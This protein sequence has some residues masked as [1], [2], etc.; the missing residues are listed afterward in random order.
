L[1]TEVNSLQED[2]NHRQLLSSTATQKERKAKS[3]AGVTIEH[4]D[5]IKDDF[6]NSRPW[7]LTGGVGVLRQVQPTN[8]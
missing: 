3:K 8:S 4:L 1:D 7:I 5:I 2:G 6:W